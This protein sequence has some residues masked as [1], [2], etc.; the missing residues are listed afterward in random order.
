MGLGVT[1]LVLGACISVAFY[2]LLERKIL[3]YGQ[4]RKGPTKVG[5][6]GLFQP[7]AD[8]IKLVTKEMNQQTGT[9][10][11]FFSWSPFVG[12]FLSLLIWS[13]YPAS[14]NPAGFLLDLLF[15]FC[16]SS[17]TVYWV[18]L[19]G[20]SSNSKYSFY[21]GLRAAAQAISY[22]AS[23]FVL[24]ITA[25]F[26]SGCLSLSN[27]SET[28]LWWWPAVILFPVFVMWFISTVAETNR[29]PFDFVE[30]ESEL[31]SGYNV[32]YGGGGFVILFL[33]EYSNI[34]FLSSFTTAGFLASGWFLG[35]SIDLSLV[36]KLVLLS[37]VVIMFRGAYPRLR[38]DKL[39]MLAWK[40]FLPASLGILAGLLCFL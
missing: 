38:Y 24:F 39:M 36:C 27:H 18:L 19:A 26:L 29:A 7:F 28:L 15:F 31:V 12:L 30:G 25:G 32:E 5:P 3:S 10:S 22:E 23:F 14:S 1:V 40:C 6:A 8:V 33:F 21:G 17:F 16:V 13:I 35:A 11:V 20:W 37:C 2:T 34:L 4:T 9:N